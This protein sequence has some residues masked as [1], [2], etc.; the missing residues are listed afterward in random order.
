MDQQLYP[1]GKLNISRLLARRRCPAGSNT[2]RKSTAD[3]LYSFELG[4]SAS[5]LRGG[6]EWKRGREEGRRARM[7]RAPRVIAKFRPY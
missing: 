2:V 5:R 1:R 7:L 6:K 3:I 4:F